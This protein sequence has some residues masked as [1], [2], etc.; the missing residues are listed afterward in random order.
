MELFGLD[1]DVYLF[2][3]I[4]AIPTFFVLRWTLKKIIKGDILLRRALT[5]AGTIILTHFI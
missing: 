5:W 2:N 1:I 4:L 3:L